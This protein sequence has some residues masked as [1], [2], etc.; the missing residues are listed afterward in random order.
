MGRAYRIA[1]ICGAC[2]LTFGVAIFLLWLLTRWQW[3]MTAGVYTI[4][5]GLVAIVA[6]VVALAFFY[7]AASQTPT[8]SRR[9]L[10][11]SVAVCASLFLSNFLV[12]GGIIAAVIAIETCYT[13]VVHNSS[14]ERLEDVR[15]FGG[16]C[17]EWLGA[18][19]PGGTARASFWVQHDGVLRFRAR[20]AAKTYSE[21]I[22]Y[23]TNG[24]GGHTI[25]TV[26]REGTVSI[27]HRDS[28]E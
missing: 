14:T 5:G 25:V 27:I 4:C 3:L 16:G 6:G 17:D 21:T 7:E 23:V 8:I 2:P 10:C 24:M 19:P 1:L 12:A 9:R 11:L 13:V 22:G 20:S 15:V 18:I 28:T 26:N